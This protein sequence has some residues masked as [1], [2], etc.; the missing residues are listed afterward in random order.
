[1]TYQSNGVS[2]LKIAYIGGGSRGWAWTLMNDLTKA[3]DL[4]GSVYLY[5]IDF[6]AAYNNEL[7]GNKIEHSGW[8]YKAVETIG[9][10]LT[11]ADFVIISILPATFDEMQVDV[12]SCE[13]YGIYQSVGDTTGP[14]GFFRTMR[15]IP[16]IREIARAIRDFCPKA[17]VINY[18]NPMANCIKAL[19]KEFPAIKA[20]GCC[21][22]VFGT[23]KLLSHALEELYGITDSE[24]KDICV[25]V[26]GVN[27]FTWF[28]KAQYR[29][30]DLFEVYRK[31]VDRYYESGYEKGKG[32]GWQKDPFRGAFRVRF[33][34][35]RRFGYIAAAGDRH[36][37]EF[38]DSGD[39]LADPETVTKWMF[40]LTTVDFRRKKQAKRE[41]EGA[42]LLSGAKAFTL[43]ESGE[44]GVD[45]IRALLGLKDR[46]TN[47]NLPNV[48]QIPNLPLGCIVET[49]AIFR[50]NTLIPVQAGDV[51]EAIFY[52]V[53][54]IAEE[55]ERAVEAAFSGDLKACLDAFKQDHL[56][57][58][59]SDSEKEELFSTMYEGTKEYLKDYR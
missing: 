10:A 1:M 23:Q 14:G 6:D 12:H 20:F 27:H 4:S 21:H 51:P 56:L 13:K 34:L 41:E 36:L 29:D 59:L 24:R 54:R 47:V 28:T 7:I 48:G 25:N 5:D 17:W 55:N 2:D 35:F 26:V 44:E 9:E 31:F 19:Y 49:N 30:M 18:T 50:A 53:N 3:N 16:M 45:Q 42:M 15:T 22:E 38:M 58:K 8:K 11:G 40:G 46:I 39:Y 37:A 57:K 43:K 52:H 33:D 32:E